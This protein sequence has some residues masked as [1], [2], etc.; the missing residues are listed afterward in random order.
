MSRVGQPTGS[1]GHGRDPRRV[2]ATHAPRRPRV[3]RSRGRPPPGSEPGP[4]DVELH[5]DLVGGDPGLLDPRRAAGRPGRPAARSGAA[6]PPPRSP[7][8]AARSRSRRARLAGEHGRVAEELRRPGVGRPAPH[9]VERAALHDPPVAH[10]GHPVGDGERLLLVVGDQHRGGS[11][12]RAGCRAGRSASRSRRPRSRALS[13]S[14]SRSSRGS[15]ARARASAT[16][17]RSPPERV[18]GDRSAYP[19]QAD[20]VEQLRDPLPLRGPAAGGAAAAGRRRCRATS[21]CS[22]S[23]PSWNI[24]ANPRLWVGMPARSWPS[25]AMEPEAGTSS[26]ATARSSVDL[27][28]PGGAEHRHHRPGRDLE[29]DVVDRD[30]VAEPTVR[31]RRVRSA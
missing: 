27:P 6:P 13:G 23:W 22:K 3:R 19:S 26:P 16:R 9:L 14:S 5:P 29:V 25:Y 10:H 30:R 2:D 12:R 18:A 7:P 31:S 4:V 17:W 28:Q 24:S 21:R 1:T 11:G 15:T 20:E 8:G